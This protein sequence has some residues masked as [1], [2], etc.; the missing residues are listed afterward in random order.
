MESITP[1]KWS[2]GKIQIL[3]Q[4][5]LPFKKVVINCRRYGDVVKAIKEMK[6]RG[7]P[8]I[9][10][11]AAYGIAMAGRQVKVKNYDKFAS[12]MNAIL[13]AF[14]KVRP[15][16]VN[17]GWAVDRMKKCIEANPKRRVDLIKDLLLKEAQAM[18]K[19]DIQ[20]N[21]TMA[22]LGTEFIR[23]GDTILTLCNTGALATGGLGTA[24]GV[25]KTA[26]QEGKKIKVLACETRPYLQGSRLTAWELKLARIPFNLITDSMAGH[27]MQRKQV[28]VVVVGAD[29][30]AANGDVANKIGTYMLAILAWENRLP[31]YVVAPTGTL[32]LNVPS[33]DKIPIEE[34]DS[35]EVTTVMG[36]PIAPPGVKAL[37]PAFDITPSRYVSAIITEKGVVRAPYVETLKALMTP[38]TL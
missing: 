20:N 3:D 32:D 11:T 37:N 28:N 38:P 8:L 23:E 34:R 19:E 13:E 33:G 24:L 6:V 21:Q 7:A 22:K 12:T 17:L 14:R 16:A 9:A 26:H 4:T 29:R 25:I 31:F 5:R 1:I 35:E 10:I 27:F 18:E 30:I 15:T 36:V 2:S